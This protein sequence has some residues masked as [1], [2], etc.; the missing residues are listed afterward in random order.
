ML[1][2]KAL[3]WFML[4]VTTK[5]LE[6]NEISLPILNHKQTKKINNMITVGASTN[7]SEA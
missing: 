3:F 2:T 1:K 5:D 6:L 4:R 7:D